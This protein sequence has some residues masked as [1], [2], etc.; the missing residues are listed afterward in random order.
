MEENE[1]EV[2][3]HLTQL[4]NYMAAT[5][6]DSS[7]AAADLWKFVRMHDRRSYHLVRVCMDSGN[8][9]RTVVKAIVSLHRGEVPG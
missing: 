4:V 8:D 5:L 9:Y 3:A 2:K 6:P 7:K 1:A